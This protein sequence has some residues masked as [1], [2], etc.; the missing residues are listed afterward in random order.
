MEWRRWRQAAAAAHAL[1]AEEHRVIRLRAWA[2]GHGVLRDV[3]NDL[4]ARGG[5]ATVSGLGDAS[6]APLA[7][8]RSWQG[9][10]LGVGEFQLVRI[11]ETEWVGEPHLRVC[12]VSGYFGFSFGKCTRG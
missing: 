9:G 5:A 2:V 12:F 7:A 3:V 6:L 8:V 1:P 4:P 11:G 10:I